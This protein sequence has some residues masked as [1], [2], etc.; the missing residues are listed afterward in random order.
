M[1][2]DTR[3]ILQHTKDGKLI[4]RIGSRGMFVVNREGRSEE[5]IG[6]HLTG[7]FDNAEVRDI[8]THSVAA[9]GRWVSDPLYGCEPRALLPKLLLTDK[10]PFDR[11]ITEYVSASDTEQLSL[12]ANNQ[13]RPAMR[14]VGVFVEF[15]CEQYRSH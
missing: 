15:G 4:A 11:E 10:E 13:K 8:G 3:G 9:R 12:E 2:V 6:G 1:T 7:K 5:E 14:R